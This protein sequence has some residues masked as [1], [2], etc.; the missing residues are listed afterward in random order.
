MAE[1]LQETTVLTINQFS[2]FAFVKIEAGNKKRKTVANERSNVNTLIIELLRL[3]AKI[4]K[5]SIFILGSQFLLPY[6]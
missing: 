1:K 2:L 4:M 3:G 5:F 6:L